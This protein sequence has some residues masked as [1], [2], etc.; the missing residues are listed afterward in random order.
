MTTLRPL[1]TLDNFKTTPTDEMYDLYH[2]EVMSLIGVINAH[3]KALQSSCGVVQKTELVAS[4][5]N[6]VS[7]SIRRI[8]MADSLE[9]VQSD[10]GSA[11]SLLNFSREMGF[12]SFDEYTRYSDAVFAEYEAALRRLR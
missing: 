1:F 12:L 10:K 2:H 9:Q 3:S 8:Y 6:R 11:I 7:R 4:V 5:V